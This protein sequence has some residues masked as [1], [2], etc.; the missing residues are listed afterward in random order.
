M[1][2]KSQDQIDVFI[3]LRS[4]GVSFQKIS[5]DIGVS[6]QT[7]IKW[8][9]ER[10]TE[11]DNLKAIRF[12]AFKETHKQNCSAQI[13]LLSKRLTQIQN[14]IEKRDLTALK[15]ADLFALEKETN[16]Q[17]HKLI[18]NDITVVESP[19]ELETTYKSQKI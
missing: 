2:R 7:L 10:K 12:E 8:A 4:E 3:K 15:L 11:I 14:E 5:D 13:E 19:F 6:K 16:D 9:F 1:N 18:F 17:I